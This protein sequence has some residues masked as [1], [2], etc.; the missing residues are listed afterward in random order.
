[1]VLSALY[2]SRV[3]GITQC[4]HQILMHCDKAISS[5]LLIHY[6]ARLLLTV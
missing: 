3:A 1:M 2:R 6:S 4:S 5:R